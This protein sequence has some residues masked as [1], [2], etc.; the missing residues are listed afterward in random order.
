MLIFP[1]HQEN[2]S[3]KHTQTFFTKKK[4]NQETRPPN[5]FHKCDTIQPVAEVS[6]IQNEKDE[7]RYYYFYNVYYKCSTG[8]A[9][10]GFWCR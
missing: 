2:Q 1:L 10:G 5:L 3:K 8:Y 7:A 6:R 9:A 4:T